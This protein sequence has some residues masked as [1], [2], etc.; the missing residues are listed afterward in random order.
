MLLYAPPGISTEFVNSASIPDFGSLV[1]KAGIATLKQWECWEWTDIATLKLKGIWETFNSDKEMQLP[2]LSERNYTLIP[3]LTS[4]LK[5][6]ILQ[7]CSTERITA[8]VSFTVGLCKQTC[9][10]W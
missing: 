3:E 9:E 7:T 4:E 10:K 2:H 8:V 1:Q 5:T 6:T